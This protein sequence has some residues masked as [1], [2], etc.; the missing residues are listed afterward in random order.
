MPTPP[1]AKTQK[2]LVLVAF[3]EAVRHH[4]KAQ[5]LSQEAFADQCGI[6]R[7]YMG[8]IERGERNVALLNVAKI[9]TS[10]G[11]EFSELFG[12]LD[13]KSRKAFHKPG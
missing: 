2:P 12:A 10:L 5:G 11:L 13:N 8:G 1:I 9:V 7:S 3:G 4:R 6:D